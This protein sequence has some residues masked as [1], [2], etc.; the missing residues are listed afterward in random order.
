[1]VLLSFIHIAAAAALALV[2]HTSLF[3]PHSSHLTPH[4]SHSTPLL[5]IL[6]YTIVVDKSSPD[7][8]GTPY[9]ATNIITINL[10]FIGSPQT[11]VIIIITTLYD[12]QPDLIEQQKQLIK[13]KRS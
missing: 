9:I 5:Q 11:A 1:M 8:Q 7:Y 13:L 6:R 10:Y 3:T 2:H 12:A 4:T